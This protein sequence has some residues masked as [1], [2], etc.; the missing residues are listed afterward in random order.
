MG[1]YSHDTL[2]SSESRENTT[3]KNKIQKECV[4]H[5]LEP[6]SLRQICKSNSTKILKKVLEA[7]PVVNSTCCIAEDLGLAPSTHV[8][9]LEA[10]HRTI[11]MY[12]QSLLNIYLCYF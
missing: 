11:S 4:E 10:V 6:R 7:S 8:E 3:G 12:V 1:A 5:A 2:L 9:Q